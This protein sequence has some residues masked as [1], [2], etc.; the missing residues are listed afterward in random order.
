[1]TQNLS[2]EYIPDCPLT[3]LEEPRAR[4]PPHLPLLPADL[5]QPHRLHRLPACCS[6]GGNAHIGRPQ[7]VLDHLVHDFKLAL[8]LGLF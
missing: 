7:T 3:H 4:L 8:T 5:A 1:M 6:E 2:H